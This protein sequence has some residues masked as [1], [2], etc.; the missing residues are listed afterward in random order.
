MSD[1]KVTVEKVMF[2]RQD[3]IFW[4]AMSKVLPEALENDDLTDEEYEE[5]KKFSKLVD[6]M[7]E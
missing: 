6:I 4:S 1:V 3:Q 5:L 7:V 2:H